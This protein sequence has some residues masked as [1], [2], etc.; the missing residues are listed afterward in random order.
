[1]GESPASP[2][3]A[4]AR[5]RA[6]RPAADRVVL[7]LAGFFAFVAASALVAVAALR[8][9]TVDA[10]LMARVQRELGALGVPVSMGLQLELLPPRIVFTHVV[11]PS[12]DGSDPA[13]SVARVEVTPRLAPLL[14][15]R[16]LIDELRLERP[17]VR[18]VVKGG[19]VR[20]LALP[21]AAKSDSPAN[22]IVSVPVRTL[23]ISGATVDLD[24]EGDLVVIGGLD[25]DARL[26]DV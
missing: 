5:A 23:A 1:M 8:T 14:V 2:I 6:R 4:A 15:G 16:I 12:L 26:G 7:L 22:P 9:P 11:V 24:L 20:N 3:L 19:A 18:L 25:A 21:K 17:H 10:W 13:L